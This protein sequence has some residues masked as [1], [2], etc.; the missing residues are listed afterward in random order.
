MKKSTKHII[1]FFLLFYLRGI[2]FGQS[3]PNLGE[4]NS[5]SI[6]TSIGNVTNT[7]LSYSI[8][9]IGTNSGTISGFSYNINGIFH[10]TDPSSALASSDLLS[11]YTN[12][13][14][15]TPTSTL[16]STIGNGQIVN[17]GVHQI[18]SAAL[19]TG[20]LLL[21]AQGDPDAV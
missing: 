6:F 8:G 18:T 21:D 20:T 4:L 13:G 1:L 17:L 12:L 14:G 7:G 15:Q 5:Y 2:Y 11:V 9:N 16:G 3:A 10:D 19:L